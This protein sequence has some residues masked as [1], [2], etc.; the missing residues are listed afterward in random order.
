MRVVDAIRRF[1][2]RMVD[3]PRP[4]SM[5]EERIADAKYATVVVVVMFAAYAVVALPFWLVTGSQPYVLFVVFGLIGT[6]VAS[7]K[8]WNRWTEDD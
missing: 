4:T 5:E 2:R 8:S 3:P 7:A 6:V 1:V